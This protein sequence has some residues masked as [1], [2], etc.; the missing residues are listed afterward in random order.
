[1]AKRQVSPTIFDGIDFPPYEFVEYPKML[2][3]K[4]PSEPGYAEVLVS[5][6]SDERAL[7][8]GHH[9]TPA[10]AIAAPA[11]GPAASAPTK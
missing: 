11:E 1:M 8:K 3:K 7:G 6:P 5:S 9:K 4:T 10:E 2:Y